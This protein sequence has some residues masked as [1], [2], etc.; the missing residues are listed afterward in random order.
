MAETT[1]S[2]DSESQPAVRR[3]ASKKRKDSAPEIAFD[4]ERDDR[5]S[6]I[7]ISSN[8][9][10]DKEEASRGPVTKEEND[11]TRGKTQI[12]PNVNIPIKA[13][14]SWEV[15]DKG[16]KRVLERKR[17]PTQRYGIDVMKIKKV[18]EEA[19]PM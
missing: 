18:R 13:S 19:E 4:F 1:S 5:S 3:K 14:T 7:E 12:P 11:E 15:K 6:I 9:T 2:S 17:V 16:P 10:D 8:T